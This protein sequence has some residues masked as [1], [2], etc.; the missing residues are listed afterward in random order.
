MP[1]IV[2]IVISFGMNFSICEIGERVSGAFD[3]IND[4]FDEVND[5]YMLPFELQKMLPVV[6][7]SV[8]QPIYLECFGS[9]SCTRDTFKRVRRRF[10]VFLLFSA[11]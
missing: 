10:R 2:E 7:M 3:E 1:L 5:W 6:V 9:I 11:D 4:V 8:Q